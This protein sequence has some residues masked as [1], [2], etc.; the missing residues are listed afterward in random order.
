MDN[1]PAQ[2]LD[3]KEKFPEPA[4]GLY[5]AKNFSTADW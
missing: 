1:G 4:A 2:Q 5:D 3:T